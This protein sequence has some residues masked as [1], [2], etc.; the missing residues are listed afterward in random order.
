[1]RLRAAA[2]VALAVPLLL[3]AG[4]G[5]DAASSGTTSAT[6]SD[7]AVS[8]DASGTD[9]SGTDASGTD[10]SSSEA[11]TP[12]PE[13]PAASSVAAP[14]DKAELPTVS[15]KFG[16]KPTVTFPKTQAPN[17]L[18]RQVLIEGSGAEVQKSDWLIAHYSGQIW[19]GK[20]FDNSYD[21]KQP[22]GFQI[23]VGGVVSG[24]DVGLVG[25]KTGSR[26]LLSLPPADGYQSA[27]NPQA[28]I[29]GTD[30]IVFVIDIVKVIPPTQGGQ[31]DVPTEKLPATVPT[32]TGDLGKQ[33]TVKVGASAKEPTKNQVLTISKGTGPKVADNDKLL[34]Q[35]EAV[36]WDNQPGGSTWK[37]DEAAQA[38][39]QQAGLQQVPVQEGSPFAQLKG[40]TEG[41]RVLL[42]IP[43]T[44]ADATQGTQ[45]QPA[46]AVVIDV[47]AIS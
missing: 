19:D 39:G 31:T 40:I 2:V 37:V 30:T 45:A 47:V 20:V 17:T 34:V 14:V 10:A 5:N 38:Q 42:L 36:T 15:G 44:A 22:T 43:A 41:S 9:A 35:Y 25:M 33:P 16:E 46:I 13:V 8:S 28:G 11:P 7:A 29:K 12:G 21:R 27:G 3:L 26:V 32:V 4:C 1:M 23:G 18:Q 24:W 6:G